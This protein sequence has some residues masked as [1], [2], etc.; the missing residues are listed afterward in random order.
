M[1]GVEVEEGVVK[2]LPSIT[3]HCR[4]YYVNKA[5]RLNPEIMPTVHIRYRAKNISRSRRDGTYG[6]LDYLEVEF[7]T[8]ISAGV[9]IK[10]DLSVAHH[11]PCPL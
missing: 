6:E 10:V 5:L 2:V 11:V 8:S 3:W 9:V 7:K 1:R 4:F